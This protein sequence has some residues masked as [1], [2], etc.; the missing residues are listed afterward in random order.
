VERR[1][2]TLSQ[3]DLAADSLGFFRWG[4]V[5]GK[6]LLTNDAAEWVF[7]SE[8]EFDDLLA[9]RVVEGHARF[10]EL[11]RLGFV[12]DGL[13][14]D[15]LST[16][17]AQRNRHV[18]RGPHVHVVT[19]TARSHAPAANGQADEGPGVDMSRETIESI[20]DLA[21]QGTSP[22]L[23][24]ELRGRGGEPLLNF[25]AL[26]ELVELARSRNERAAGK[27]LR[28]VVASNLTAMTEE[29]AEWLIANDVLVSTTLDGPAA[30]HDENRKHLGGSAH[31]DVVRWIEYF[32]R[33]YAEL[34]RD[35]G[36]WHVDALVRVTRRSLGAGREI[37]DEYVSRGLR[38]VHL[39]PLDSS[40]YDG[41]TWKAIGYTADEYLAFY[42]G[43]LNY[44]LEL[45]RRGVDLTERLAAVLATK[46]LTTDDPGIVDLQSPYGAGTGQIAYDVDGRAF[47]CEEARAVDAAGDPIFELGHVRNLN[48]QGIARHPTVRAIA[49]ASLLDVQPMC[50]ECWNKPFC[51][52]SPV[53]NFVAQ[54]DLFGQRPHCFDC[55]EHMAVSTQLFELLADASDTATR[56]ILERWTAARSPHA[57][58]ARIAKEAP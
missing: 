57:V 47:P 15:A 14:L 48:V 5:G 26:R 33:R 18:R 34:G 51:G 45:N 41:E 30:L 49:A 36:Q 32:Q 8:A 21:L 3:P 9:G 23:T 12:R 10:D 53:R 43:V 24:F 4:R 25:D 16:R 56:E 13:D 11:Q 28:F 42:R 55:K 46:I 44:V 20:V 58:D 35:A 7:L 31:A 40:R 38:S 29:I 27:T 50:A 17:V 6:V 19:L 37:V 2:L 22:T 54:G 1:S 52:F 39:R